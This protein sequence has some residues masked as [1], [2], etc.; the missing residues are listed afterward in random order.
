MSAKDKYQKIVKRIL[1]EVA[2]MMPTDE[3]VRTELIFDDAQGHY[4]LGQV[5]WEGKRRVD[6]VFLHVDVCDGKIWVQ[7]DGTNLGIA[8]EMV[9]AGVPKDHIV[10]AFR[11][12]SRRPDTEYAVA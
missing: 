10:L 4:Q 7:H 12:P 5:G 3:N 6:S 11:H 9:R 1:R 2:G 8:E